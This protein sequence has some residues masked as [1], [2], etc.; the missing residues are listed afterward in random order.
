[1]KTL[2]NLFGLLLV[3]V[4]LNSVN[5][6]VVFPGQ[7][8]SMISD[9]KGLLV[10]ANCINGTCIAIV[11]L[12]EV[13][14]TANRPESHLLEMVKSNGIMIYKADLPVIEIIANRTGANVIPGVMENGN[15]IG[16]IELPLIEIISDFPYNK[17]I[18]INSKGQIVVDLPEVNIIGS[19]I[20]NENV[21]IA[22]QKLPSMV[23]EKNTNNINSE[24]FFALIVP[25]ENTNF[26]DNEDV[27]WFYVSLKKCGVDLNGNEIC[28]IVSQTRIRSSEIIR[29]QFAKFLVQE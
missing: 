6:A 17:L 12:P 9:G 29:N 19:A 11:N 22:L 16:T 1:M 14:I 28:E 4:S 10:K 2:Q 13:E 3:L 26:V 23:S 21:Q 27:D 20:E 18:A 8:D 5:A 24:N 25:S 7:N 15:I